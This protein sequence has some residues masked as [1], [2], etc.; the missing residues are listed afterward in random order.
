[1]AEKK[2]P[3]NDPDKKV[4][5]EVAGIVN[6]YNAQVTAINEFI[7]ENSEVAEAQWDDEVRDEYNEK[8]RELDQT[9]G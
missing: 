5:P 9:I 3:I 8:L 6:R 7:D 4:S 1:M 2:I